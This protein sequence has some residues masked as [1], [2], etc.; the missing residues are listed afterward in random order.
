MKTLI[1]L[2]DDTVQDI[3][4]GNATAQVSGGGGPFV[5]LEKVVALFAVKY[6]PIIEKLFSGFTTACGTGGAP[7]K[8]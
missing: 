6:A 4:A 2:T 1:K 3:V 7:P 5:E 8:D